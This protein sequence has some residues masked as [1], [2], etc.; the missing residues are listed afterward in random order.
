MPLGRIFLKKLAVINR[1]RFFDDFF[2][3]ISL[4]VLI[5]CS[6]EGIGLKFGR[7]KLGEDGY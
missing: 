3:C 2:V 1:E 7:V 4:E 6:L 5:G